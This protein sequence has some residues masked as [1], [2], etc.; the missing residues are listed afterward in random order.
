M[1]LDHLLTYLSKFVDISVK[2]IGVSAGKTANPGQEKCL[3]RH[4]AFYGTQ[5]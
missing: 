4:L 5:A 3:Y 1:V 2:L